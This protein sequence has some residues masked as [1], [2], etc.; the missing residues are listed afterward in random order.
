ML[1]S[2]KSLVIDSAVLNPEKGRVWKQGQQPT[3][4]KKQILLEW[5]IVLYL[6]KRHNEDELSEKWK[7]IYFRKT[8]TWN[9]KSFDNI[10]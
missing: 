1:S 5:G 8:F 3:Y 9:I 10:D 6:R 2:L 7:K 4:Y